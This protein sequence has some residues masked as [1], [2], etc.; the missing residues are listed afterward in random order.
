MQLFWRTTKLPEGQCFLRSR[1]GWINLFSLL[2]IFTH[3]SWLCCATD[4]CCGW[5]RG[6]GPDENC[7]LVYCVSSLVSVV[8]V[9]GSS[10]GAVGNSFLGFLFQTSWDYFYNNF[11]VQYSMATKALFRVQVTV[12]FIRSRCCC[13]V[14]SANSRHFRL[15]CVWYLVSHIYFQSCIVVCSRSLFGASFYIVLICI[16]YNT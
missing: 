10:V 8:R 4:S 3:R 2:I 9:N 5:G 12:L 6:G 13:N 16:V 11:F 15:T 14:S 1:G 7:L